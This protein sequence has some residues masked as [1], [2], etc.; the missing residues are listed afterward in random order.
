MKDRLRTELRKTYALRS[1]IDQTSLMV[2]VLELFVGLVIEIAQHL[3]E[4]TDL[5]TRRKIALSQVK[6]NCNQKTVTGFHFEQQFGNQMMI[7]L[8]TLPTKIHINRSNG[9]LS[10]ES[11][12]N[13][14]KNYSERLRARNK[15]KEV[16]ITDTNS[17]EERLRIF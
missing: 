14:Q 1:L 12:I 16:E 13:D 17:W 4:Q 6:K 7:I 8:I 2:G 11:N 3:H 10:R 15:T 9:N 5:H